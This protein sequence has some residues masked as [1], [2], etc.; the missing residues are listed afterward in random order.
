MTD[1]LTYP[2][3]TL[4]APS[5]TGRS[6]DELKCMGL[7]SN[8]NAVDDASW[9]LRWDQ[10]AGNTPPCI[11]VFKN[12]IEDGGSGNDGMRGFSLTKLNQVRDDFRYMF[13]RAFNQTNGKK[14]TVPGR[15]GY[16][17]FQ[18]I[19]ID[20]CSE[21]PGAC[22]TTS[23]TYCGSCNRDQISS[24]D[25]RVSLCG[26]FAPALNSTTYSASLPSQWTATCDPLCT[27]QKT[28][29]KRQNDGTVPTCAA[30]VCVIDNVSVQAADSTTG[31]VQ[32]QQICPACANANSENQCVCVVNSSVIDLINQIN[33]DPTSSFSN[34]AVFN[35][36]CPNATCL[37]VNSTTGAATPVA[38]DAYL[39]DPSEL[40]TATNTTMPRWPW[41]AFGI[42]ILL[43][44]IIILAAWWYGR[45]QTVYVPHEWQP[46][47]MEPGKRPRST[48]YNYKAQKK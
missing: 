15:V 42:I 37:Q 2:N 44:G 17:L 20:A 26:C 9:R 36:Y 40:L 10:G 39:Q 12:L 35:Q 48:D 8:G 29:K 32:F 16:D 45:H 27:R 41:Y 33:S 25:A 21:I 23:S 47:P 30:T 7:D 28:A 1:C 5:K 6:L 38:C 4:T 14:I 13:S 34:K 31:T 19:L 22:E 43:I 46:L 11:D 24:L 3:A 18:P